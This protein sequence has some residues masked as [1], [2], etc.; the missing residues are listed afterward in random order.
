MK[1][2]FCLFIS[3]IV[4]I[5][6]SGCMVKTDKTESEKITMMEY[7]E[8]KYDEKFEFVNI[9]TQ[10]WSAD[11]TEMIVKSEK[12]PN[13]SIIVQKN[14]TSG[15]MLDNYISIILNQ[16]IEREISSIVTSIYGENKTF[17]TPKR[18]VLPSTIEK[19]ASVTDLLTTVPY[20]SDL[21][22]FVTKEPLSKDD[23]LNK[24]ISVIKNKRYPLTFS[25]CYVSEEEFQEISQNNYTELL[26][27][28][29]SKLIA[30]G[31]F[32]MNES[33]ELTYKSWR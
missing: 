4:A 27:K 22:V 13:V 24:F 12:H 31:D 20:A 32:V 17:N 1:Q 16:D 28:N 9:N 11:Y 29:R 10:V 3:I 19:D 5:G 30:C 18:K 6:V 23:D 21:K 14:N 33:V 26:T 25:I 7:L 8:Q 15:E 2:L